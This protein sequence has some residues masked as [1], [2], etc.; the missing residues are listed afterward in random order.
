[1]I[2]AFKYNQS[3]NKARLRNL[4]EEIDTDGLSPILFYAHSMWFLSLTSR[5]NA[6]C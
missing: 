5:T 3:L 6:A 2:L 4:K 1:M